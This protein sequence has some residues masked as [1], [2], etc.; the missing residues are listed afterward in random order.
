[1][2][3]PDNLELLLMLIDAIDCLGCS[4]E[5]I[6]EEYE[7]KDK[8]DRLIGKSYYWQENIDGSYAQVTIP[9]EQRALTLSGL[10]KIGH[11]D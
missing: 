1:M 8:F 6:E 7:L 10:L 3:N 4:D 11:N 5:G 2:S 9:K